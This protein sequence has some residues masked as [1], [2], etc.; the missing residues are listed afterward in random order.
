MDIKSNEA[1]MSIFGSYG[2]KTDEKKNITAI[3]LEGLGV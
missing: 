3:W 1:I 2:F